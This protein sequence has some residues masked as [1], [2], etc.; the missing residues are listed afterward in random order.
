MAS[1]LNMY[2]AQVNEYKF[3]IE[4]LTREL[5]VSACS[6]SSASSASS[7]W[8][9]VLL[10]RVLFL[11]STRPLLTGAT[12]SRSVASSWPRAA[13][14]ATAR[15]DPLPLGSPPCP[16]RRRCSDGRP[17][18]LKA[19]RQRLLALLVSWRC[20]SPGG[21]DS[22]RSFLGAWYHLVARAVL[23]RVCGHRVSRSSSPPAGSGSLAAGSASALAERRLH[24]HRALYSLISAR[25]DPDVDQP[26]MARGWGGR[27]SVLR[28]R[29]R[30]CEEAGGR[31]E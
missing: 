25:F 28:Q 7:A 23:T 21:G 3:E 24:A 11:F 8:A 18:S 15:C 27:G 4:R 19:V 22:P 29:K 13:A 9:C 10:P 1:E 20:A 17:Q 31:D 26:R 30:R 14:S 2:Q 6:A 5:Q 12:T 16:R